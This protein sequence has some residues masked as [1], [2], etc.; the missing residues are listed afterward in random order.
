MDNLEKVLHGLNSCGFQDGFAD[1]CNITEC[2]YREHGA[3]C[4]HELTHDAGVLISE[5]LKE[6]EPVEPVPEMD[7]DWT[8]GN[9]GMSAVGYDDLDA[10]GFVPVKFNYC[11]NCGRKVEWE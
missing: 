10:S 8:C 3:W 2:P 9:C 7:D 6:K 11:P 1:I 4:V 5:L